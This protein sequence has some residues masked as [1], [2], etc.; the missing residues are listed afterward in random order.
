MPLKWPLKIW[1]EKEVLF[2]IVLNLS[3][4]KQTG[5]SPM[6]KAF[7]H[8]DV[9]F[10]CQN[11]LTFAPIYMSSRVNKTNVIYCKSHSFVGFILIVYMHR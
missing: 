6:L 11:K 7:K 10:E 5:S 8:A 1:K 4:G 2:I 9:R 3:G